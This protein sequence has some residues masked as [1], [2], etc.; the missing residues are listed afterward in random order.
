MKVP[1]RT[2]FLAQVVATTVSCF[3]QIATL[4]FALGSI[5]NVCDIHQRDRFTCPGGR[6]FFSCN[7]SPISLSSYMSI[8]SVH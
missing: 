7:T 4:N 3:V 8:L 6:V 1:P 5:D 2:M